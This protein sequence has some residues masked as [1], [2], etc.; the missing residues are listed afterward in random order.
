MVLFV[1]KYLKPSEL[2]ILK[3]NGFLY[4]HVILQ[5]IE[6]QNGGQVHLFRQ[7]EMFYF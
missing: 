4:D 6:K 2:D 1:L 5:Y 3:T 7:R